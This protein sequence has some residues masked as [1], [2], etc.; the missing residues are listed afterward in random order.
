M[1]K[2]LLLLLVALSCGVSINAQ[3]I[4]KNEVDKFTKKQII[5]T[6]FEKIANDKNAMNKMLGADSGGIHKNVWIAFLQNGE[7][8]FLRLKWSCNSVLA[9]SDDSDI[10]FLDSDGNT[11]TFDNTSFTISGK[12]EAATGFVGSAIYGLDIYATGNISALK[13]KLIT[14]MRIQ[15]TDGYIDF[16]IDKKSSD[17]ITK[18]YDM[19]EATL[20][21]N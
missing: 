5:E 14:D 21:K 12:G 15:T 16:K 4:K 18:T 10:I 6:S 19:F 7:T 20:D 2:L 1:K 13:G 11:Y 9:L 17:K 3:K 8:S